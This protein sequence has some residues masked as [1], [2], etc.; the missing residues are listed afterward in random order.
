MNSNNGRFKPWLP[1]STLAACWQA[2]IEFGEDACVGYLVVSSSAS[3][4]KVTRR[5]RLPLCGLSTTGK[6]G[7]DHNV[8]GRSVSLPCT[9]GLSA[10][11]RSP[12][13]TRVEG[14][15]HLSRT[16]WTQKGDIENLR[17]T[18]LVATN[19]GCPQCSYRADIS[20]ASRRRQPGCELEPFSP[21]LFICAIA[22]ATMTRGTPRK[23]KI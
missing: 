4:R 13:H 6:E 21:R 23:G 20:G 5:Y 3:L 14:S 19:C 1:S 9:V 17:N 8:L 11:P 2:G 22:V 7:L 10:L 18:F 12:L 16:Q 15:S